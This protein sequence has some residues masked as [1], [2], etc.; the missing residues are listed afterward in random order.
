MKKFI[1]TTAFGIALLFLTALVVVPQTLALTNIELLGKYIFFDNVS[2]PDRMGCHTCH[3][4]SDGWTGAVS[5]V[6]LHQVAITGAN[7]HTVGTLKPPSCAY[8]SFIVPS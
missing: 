8:S 1:F 2:V 4:P 7:P 6:N 3:N 5:G